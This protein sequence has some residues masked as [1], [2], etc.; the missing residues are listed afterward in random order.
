[1]KKSF[2]RD[3]LESFI[4]A[5]ENNQKTVKKEFK[6]EPLILMIKIV[7]NSMYHKNLVLAKKE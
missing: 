6:L 3:N 1:M 2:S 7:K 5:F 4:R